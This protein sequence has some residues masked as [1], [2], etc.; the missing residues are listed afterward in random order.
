MTKRLAFAALTLLLLA[1]AAGAQVFHDLPGVVTTQ[2]YQTEPQVVCA[3]DDTEPRE[4]T[5]RQLWGRTVYSCTQ[6]GVTSR[7]SNLPPSR[8][9]DLRGYDW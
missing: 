1:P 2:E 7:G 5:T 9:R 6:G 4:R 8:E 3:P